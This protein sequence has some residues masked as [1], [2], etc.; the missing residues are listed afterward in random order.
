MAQN[1]PHWR[2]RSRDDVTISR[3]MEEMMITAED[4]IMAM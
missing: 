4:K 1:I 2:G 3:V